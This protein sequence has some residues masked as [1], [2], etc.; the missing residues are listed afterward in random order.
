M[1]AAAAAAAF[2]SANFLSVP[3]GLLLE[4][5]DLILSKSSLLMSWTFFSE[6]L[7]I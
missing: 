2:F 1:E 6:L 7:S 4:D 5:P 3:W